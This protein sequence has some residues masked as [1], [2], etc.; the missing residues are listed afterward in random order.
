[1]KPSRP[2]IS[3]L[4]AAA[5]LVIASAVARAQTP[6]FDHLQCFP[7][8][9]SNLS[10][11]PSSLTADLIP[12]QAPPFAPAPG[13]R[14]RTSPRLL[15]VDVAKENVQPPGSTLPVSGEPTRDYLCYDVKCPK[16]A[17]GLAGAVVTDQFGEHRITTRPSKYLCVPAIHG[18]APRPTAAPCNQL[19]GGQCSDTCPGADR[20]LFVPSGFEVVN[21]PLFPVDIIGAND[22]RCV[23]PEVGCES[24]GS[25]SICALAGSSLLCP[26]RD[27][28]C[29]VDL[30]ACSCQ[31]GGPGE[32]CG[33][34]T[35]PA[36]QVCCNSLM[37]ICADPGQVCAQ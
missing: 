22:C 11:A 3:S 9:G 34:T 37:N 35:C 18:P 30:G 10:S 12:A 2:L 32:S 4:I 26:D 6:L 15:C 23:P 24:V 8:S 14:V 17:G 25:A 1:M 5:V 19:G 36:G 13:C 21:S 16:P 28:H 20:C 27:Q 29:T 31:V 7:V 33:T